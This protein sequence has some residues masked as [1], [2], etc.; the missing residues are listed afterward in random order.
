MNLGYLSQAQTLSMIPFVPNFPTKESIANSRESRV[1][2]SLIEEAID[3]WQEGIDLAI[4]S[5]SSIPGSS[6]VSFFFD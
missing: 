5:C 6:H 2:V 4:K 1:K 3:Y